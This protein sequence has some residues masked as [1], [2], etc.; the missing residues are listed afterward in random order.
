MIR[1]PP[2]ASALGPPGK[3]VGSMR[4]CPLLAWR[5]LRRKTGHQHHPPRHTQVHT[6]PSSLAL[7]DSDLGQATHL[8]RNKTTDGSKSL[9]CFLCDNEGRPI[10]S[11]PCPPRQPQITEGELYSN[12]KTHS[13]SL[14]FLTTGLVCSTTDCEIRKKSR[15]S[16]LSSSD[17]IP[18]SRISKNFK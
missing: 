6:L 3:Q 13:C 14:S 7:W 11:T 16:P 18:H 5:K 4:S 10:K 9:S 2:P 8:L 15:I 12:A 17:L 1:R